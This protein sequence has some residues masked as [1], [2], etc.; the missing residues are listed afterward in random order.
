VVF[1]SCTAAMNGERSEDA[2][3]YAL[4]FMDPGWCLRTLA[5][6]AQR[7]IVGDVVHSCIL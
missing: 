5:F 6:L 1:T 2:M 3:Q 7:L 4:F